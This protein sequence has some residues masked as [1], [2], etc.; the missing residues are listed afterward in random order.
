MCYFPVE[1]D[2]LQQKAVLLLILHTAFSRL[3]LHVKCNLFCAVPDPPTGVSFFVFG[4]ADIQITW[5]MPNR[6]SLR[7]R[8]QTFYVKLFSNDTFTGEI[9]VDQP[10][11]LVNASVGVV[12]GRTQDIAVST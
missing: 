11:V 12:S 4:T 6:D 5:T 10:S 9:Q 8:S 3:N 7:G 1:D 2:L